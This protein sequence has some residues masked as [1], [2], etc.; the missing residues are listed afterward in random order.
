[1]PAGGSASSISLTNIKLFIL[2]CCGNLLPSCWI[3]K[4]FQLRS[5]HCVCSPSTHLKAFVL[6]GAA[7]KRRRAPVRA[8]LWLGLPFMWVEKD[9]ARNAADN[10]IKAGI[11]R[12][13]VI[14]PLGFELSHLRSQA[15][16][17]SC[18]DVREWVSLNT[19]QDLGFCGKVTR[20]SAVTRRRYVCFRWDKGQCRGASAADV[21]KEEPLYSEIHLICFDTSFC[22]CSQSHLVRLKCPLTHSPQRCSLHV[23]KA[24]LSAWLAE[25]QEV[26]QL[27]QRL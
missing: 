17:K 7:S 19:E 12:S 2:C 6:Q 27:W 26:E 16:L 15:C 21:L 14:K 18:A 1:M 9:K 10:L 5:R 22:I 3:N 13:D 25:C 23:E 8:G 11:K 24:L 4:H 20:S